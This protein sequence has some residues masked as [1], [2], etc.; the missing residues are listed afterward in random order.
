M[1][2]KPGSL[3]KEERERISQH[4]TPK[5][6][7]GEN[8]QTLQFMLRMSSLPRVDYT[9]AEAVAERI[10][11]YFEQCVEYDIRP[12]I[13]GMCNA[14]GIARNTFYDWSV[15]NNR[16]GQGH[17][18]VTLRAKQVLAAMLEEWMQTG[19][20]NPVT[21]IFL[22]A[23]NFGYKQRVEVTQEIN[24]NVLDS[25]SPAE[26]EAR[27]AQN[28][29]D[30]DYSDRLELGFKADTETKQAEA[31]SVSKNKKTSQNG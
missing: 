25:A 14:L 16:K 29:I 31:V 6:K 27:Y 30:A 17:Q 20:I 23:N 1:G 12:G 11:Y 19:K 28:I 3:S 24:T 21:G 2:R 26:L 10:Q 15:G 4:R 5:L 9:S 13:E 18:E 7:Q 22:S 8:A